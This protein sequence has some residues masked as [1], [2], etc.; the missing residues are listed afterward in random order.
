MRNI[1]F[2]IL[3]VGCAHGTDA[4]RQVLTTTAQSL[5]AGVKAFEAFDKEHQMEILTSDKTAEAADKDI[6]AYRA[7]RAIVEKAFIDA[8]A[9]VATGLPLIDLVDKGIKKSA[10]MDAWVASVLTALQSV[11]HLLAELTK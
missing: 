8:E 7:R 1:L 2:A 3:L 6:S 10:D 9:L 11:Q 4:A 5:E